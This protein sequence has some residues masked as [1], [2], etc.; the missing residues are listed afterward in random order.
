MGLK[1]A[2]AATQMMHTGHLEDVSLPQQ[3]AKHLKHRQNH[4]RDEEADN[5]TK[6]VF[7]RQNLCEVS[8]WARV[9]PGA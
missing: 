9:G 5:T 3:G 7:V 1:I 6:T 4:A 8:D 2:K